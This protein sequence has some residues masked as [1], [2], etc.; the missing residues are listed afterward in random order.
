MSI[1]DV[2]RAQP[3]ELQPFE[4]PPEPLLSMR[5]VSKAF[6]SGATRN[7][8]LTNINLNIREG[9][10]LAVVGFSGSGKTTF[11]KLLAG[12]ESPDSGQITMDGQPIN[13]PSSER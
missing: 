11:T 2:T 8:V 9:E 1:I 3:A 13:G 4:P 10:F 6:G 12:L 7:E 5:G